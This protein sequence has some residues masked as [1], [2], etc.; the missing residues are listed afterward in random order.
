MYLLLGLPCWMLLPLLRMGVNGQKV[1]EMVGSV[2][3]PQ[4]P[5]LIWL[6]LASY[7]PPPL[8]LEAAATLA[9]MT[10]HASSRWGFS[11]VDQLRTAS[12]QQSI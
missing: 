6:S 8:H 12:C 4:G 2:G 10:L 3:S 11:H 7:I 5:S 9:T 1:V